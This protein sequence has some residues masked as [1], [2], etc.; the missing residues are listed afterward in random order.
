[1][2]DGSGAS[3]D[4]TINSLCRICVVVSV[5]DRGFYRSSNSS[6]TSLKSVDHCKQ[7]IEALASNDDVVGCFD[8]LESVVIGLFE[9]I[10]TAHEVN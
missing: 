8:L 1:V 7:V 5:G 9:L 10:H 4:C 3:N 6:S 2:D